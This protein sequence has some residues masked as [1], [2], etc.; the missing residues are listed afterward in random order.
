MKANVV[1]SYDAK[2]DSKK[3]ITLRNAN[4][5]YFHIEEFSDGK[6]ILEPRVLTRPFEVSANTLKTMD[7]SIENLKNGNV[8]AP[9]D[10]SIYGDIENV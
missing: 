7:S 6:I 4:Y 10:L 3:R 8:S 9:I 2:V 1:K 5:D